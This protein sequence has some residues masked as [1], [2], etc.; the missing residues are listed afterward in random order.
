MEHWFPK[1]IKTNQNHEGDKDTHKTWSHRFPPAVPTHG[2]ISVYK[3]FPGADGFPQ[4][5]GV[6]SHV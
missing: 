5:M 6:Y 3:V 1:G 4:S 2:Q